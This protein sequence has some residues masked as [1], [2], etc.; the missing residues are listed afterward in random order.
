MVRGIATTGLVFSL[1]SALG[2]S[3]LAD[4]EKPAACDSHFFDPDHL[5]SYLHDHKSVSIADILKDTPDC[6]KANQ[7]LVYRSGSLQCATQKAP[8]VLMYVDDVGGNGNT[9]CSF[10]SGNKVDYQAFYDKEPNIN[11]HE[12]TIECQRLNN[13]TGRFEY[14]EVNASK[15]DQGKSLFVQNQKATTSAR[16]SKI[17]PPQC[18]TSCHRGKPTSIG[19]NPRPNLENYPDW[20]GFYG[21]ISDELSNSPQEKKAYTGVYLPYKA[22]NPRYSSLP[23]TYK[24][25]KPVSSLEDLL[26]D[27]DYQRIAA[28]FTKSKLKKEIWPFR[29]AII[30]AIACNDD[31]AQQTPAPEYNDI[32]TPHQFRIDS[33]LPDEVKSGFQTSYPEF[34]S[35]LMR[36]HQSNLK[37]Q[38]ETATRDGAHDDQVDEIY[39]TDEAVNPDTPD[40]TW[41]VYASDDVFGASRLAFIGKNLG[42]PVDDWSMTFQDTISFLG[43]DNN[44][45]QIISYLSPELLDKVKDKDILDLGELTYDETSSGH[46]FQPAHV[47]AKQCDLLRKKSLATL[48]AAMQSNHLAGILCKNAQN[49]AHP[50]VNLPTVAPILTHLAAHP[51]KPALL[52]ACINC[53]VGAAVNNFPF[54]APTGVLADRLRAPV[55]NTNSKRLIDDVVDQ[56]SNGNMPRGMVI[57]NDQKDE[58]KEYF[59]WVASQPPKARN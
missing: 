24:V 7:A 27:Q 45:E 15:D 46:G 47:N 48:Q 10:N 14:Y 32:G 29:Y 18:M 16:V 17:N 25:D 1:F 26:K 30:G 38:Y 57:T 58:L 11:C 52:S 55:S 9:V 5:Q 42:L 41:N 8:R 37:A 4:A 22:Q 23:D 6:F 21:S 53:H 59:N 31:T 33:F 12:N 54:D 35:D 13:T 43:D 19:V 44:F 39:H 36:K 34:V 28:E 49:T 40:T 56:I 51:E 20:P 2:S 50:S 3:A